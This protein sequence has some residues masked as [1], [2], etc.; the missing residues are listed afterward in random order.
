MHYYENKSIKDWVAEDRPRE[1]LIAKGK[2]ALTDA[3]L[4]AT[5]ISSGTKKHSALDLAR[6]LLEKYE[7]LKQLSLV[8]VRELCQHPGIGQ[9]KASNIA[10]AFELARRGMVEEESKKSYITSHDLGA[11]L[12]AKLG[13]RS[14][15]VFHVMFLDNHCRVIMEKELFR[16]GRNATIVDPKV[17]F[18]EAITVQASRIVVCH[19]HPSGKIIPS[20]A[21]DQVTSKLV[22]YSKMVEVELIDHLVVGGRRWYSYADS[23]ELAKI[24]RKVNASFQKAAGMQYG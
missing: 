5:L 22:A 17:V 15:E 2:E 20:K 10:V 1:K 19:N 21:D 16:G 3:E 4:L 8:S 12:S 6:M 24:R 14:T 11:Y 23:G 18:S 9:A 7:G 13:N